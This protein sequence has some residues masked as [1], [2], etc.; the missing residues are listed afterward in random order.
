MKDG[1]LKLNETERISNNILKSKKTRRKH[2]EE[3]IRLF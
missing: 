1:V 2:T 3:A